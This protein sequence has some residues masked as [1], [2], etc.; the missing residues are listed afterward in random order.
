MPQ[1]LHVSTLALSGVPEAYISDYNKEES[2]FSFHK[3]SE[4]QRGES[5]CPKCHDQ[6]SIHTE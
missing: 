5:K 3:F 4:H 2:Y 6:L 1:N